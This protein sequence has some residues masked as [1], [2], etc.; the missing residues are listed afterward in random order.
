MTAMR[1]ILV[2]EY[3]IAHPNDTEAMQ[4]GNGAK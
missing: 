3:R 2:F 4:Q 1:G